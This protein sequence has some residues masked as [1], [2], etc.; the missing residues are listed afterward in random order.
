M[1]LDTMTVREALTFA[2][3][4]KLPG[5]MSGAEKAQRAL[6]VAEL[7]N[8]Q[9][10]LDSVVGSAMLRGISGRWWAEGGVPVHAY[11]QGISTCRRAWTVSVVGSAMTMTGGDKRRPSPYHQPRRLPHFTL[12]R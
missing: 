6:D 12:R 3:Q 7:L 9:K 5:S 8:L 11:P 4:L 2:A 1:I 10:S